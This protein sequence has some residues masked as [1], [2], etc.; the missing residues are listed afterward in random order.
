MR[1]EY[2]HAGLDP[3][4]KLSVD[5][6]V[7]SAIH[8]SHW[9]GNQTP[10]A[11]KADTSTEIALNL[12]GSPDR[13]QLTRGIQLITNNHFDTDGLLSV[14]TVLSGRRALELREKLIAAAEAGDFSHFSTEEGIR[15]SIAIQGSA[16]VAPDEEVGSPLANWIAGRPVVEAAHAYELVLPQVEHV[17]SHTGEFEPLWRKEWE[18]I[19]RALESFAHGESR[20]DEH[21]DVAL[22]VI[23]LTPNIFSRAGFDPTRHVA[24]FTAISRCAHGHLF[25]VAAPTRDGWTYRIDYPYYSWAETVRR[26]SIARRDFTAMV[27]RLNAMEPHSNGRWQTDA[28]ELTSAIKFFGPDDTLGSSSLTPDVVGAELRA[29]LARRA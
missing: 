8:F 18:S 4:P 1:F 23:T 20:V 10:A 15:A 21:H 22:S 28:T 3:E 24:P 26:H 7:S 13:D 6:I 5:G 25:L 2:Y 27:E 19:E 29:T 9:R 11:V 17:L 14:W 16:S 12:V